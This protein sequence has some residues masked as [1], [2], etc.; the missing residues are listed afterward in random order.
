MTNDA[1]TPTKS[2]ARRG[3]ERPLLLRQLTKEQL[4]HVGASVFNLDLILSPSVLKPTLVE[5]VAAAMASSAGCG[6]S[7]FQEPLELESGQGPPHP[8]NPDTHLF[9]PEVFGSTGASGPNPISTLLGVNQYDAPVHGASSQFSNPSLTPATL[10]SAPDPQDTRVNVITQASQRQSQAEQEEAARR[11]QDLHRQLLFEEHGVQVSAPPRGGFNPAPPRVSIDL[12]PPLQPRVTTVTPSLSAAGGVP[13]VGFPASSVNQGLLTPSHFAVSAPMSQYPHHGGSAVQ[14]TPSSAGW[15]PAYAASTATPLANTYGVGHIPAYSPVPGVALP[16]QAPHFL[17]SNLGPPPAPPLQAAPAAPPPGGDL[18]TVVARMLEQMSL[19]RTEE[20]RLRE[21]ELAAQRSM[22]AILAGR[23]TDPTGLSSAS[24]TH[25]VLD[26]LNPTRGRLGITKRPNPAA[27]REAGVTLPPQFGIV[28]DMATIDMTSAR[29]KIRSGKDSTDHDE[30]LVQ[31][32]WPNQFLER[33]LCGRV[34]HADLDPVKFACGFVTKVYCETPSQS[35]GSRE[36]NMLRI[37]M[38]LL[39]LAINTPW[40]DV[41][42]VNDALFCALE[43]KAIT[44]DSWPDLNRW[45][46][47][48]LHTIQVKQAGKRATGSPPGGQPPAKRPSDLP[49][50]NPPPAKQAKRAIMGIPGEWLREQL[51]CIK[52]NIGRCTTAAPHPSPVGASVTL[53]HICGGCL[54]L[55]KGTD[56]GHG[57]HA[58]PNKNGAGFF[59]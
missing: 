21:Q 51:V 25:A 11:A 43:R 33:M 53:R 42:M 4:V 56:G 34:K 17:T 12:G 50:V 18:S 19:D 52:F 10:T 9:S 14:H 41:L 38:L 40:S 20:R 24:T 45:W 28:G 16:P 49:A 46:E 13:S 57:M 26:V 58:C 2:P 54:F 55:K 48:A 15:L 31:E 44:W 22:Y 39:K 37:L 8:C 1:T 6:C 23:A 47:Q 27:D 29:H 5:D 32:L 7:G 59:C 30:V 36:H 35:A 3:P